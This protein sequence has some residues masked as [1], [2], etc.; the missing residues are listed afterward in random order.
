MGVKHSLKRSLWGGAALMLFSAVLASAQLFS[1]LREAT[2]P[3]PNDKTDRGLI[4]NLCHSA[5]DYRLLEWTETDIVED[6]YA[7]EDNRSVRFRDASTRFH[8]QNSCLIESAKKLAVTSI[9]LQA[10]DM[11]ETQFGTRSVP[12]LLDPEEVFPPRPECDGTNITSFQKAQRDSRTA[13]EVNVTICDAEGDFPTTQAEFSA[14]RVTEALTAEMCAYGLWLEL[15]AADTLG[16]GREYLYETLRA[17]DTVK[18]E[19]EIIF[20]LNEALVQFEQQTRQRNQNELET[21]RKLLE[22]ALRD[23]EAFTH[24]YR[25][26]AALQVLRVG[27]EKTTA[28]VNGLASQIETF[29]GQ[30]HYQTSL[31][32]VQ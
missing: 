10:K 15:S 19:Q 27:I 16:T 7:T 30:F 11:A 20:T 26:H 25:R 14:C 4:N 17:S 29:P 9:N 28:E 8:T 32:C 22:M 23:Y 21:A 5:T 1:P 18:T 12:E 2:L 31:Q 13:A 6:L 3:D 24:G